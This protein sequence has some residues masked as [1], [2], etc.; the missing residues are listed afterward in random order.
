MGLHREEGRHESYIHTY[1]LK[2]DTSFT[3][4][5]PE[6]KVR[7]V[8]S[9]GQHLYSISMLQALLHQRHG[10]WRAARGRGLESALVSR[11]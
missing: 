11:V 10:A 7:L 3:P 6:L 4:I 1:V 9:V 2:G 8:E 5:R